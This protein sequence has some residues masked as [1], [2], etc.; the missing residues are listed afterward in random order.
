MAYPTK[1]D[2]KEKA[3][4]NP[5]KAMIPDQKTSPA[6]TNKEM[7]FEAELEDFIQK[8]SRE[9][10]TKVSIDRAIIDYLQLM[11]SEPSLSHGKGVLIKALGGQRLEGTKLNLELDK[12][13]NLINSR[14]ESYAPLPEDQVK[15]KIFV[16]RMRMR[17]HRLNMP[18]LI[19]RNGKSGRR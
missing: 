2:R 10:L 7:V 12:L 11:D 4:E 13:T 17:M 14:L 6:H 18:V 16:E 19:D 5:T 1:L 15:T 9:D 3:E 8:I